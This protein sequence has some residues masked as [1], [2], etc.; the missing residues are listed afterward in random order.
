MADSKPVGRIVLVFAALLVV[1]G[2]LMKP[3]F[4]RDVAQLLRVGDVAYS[5]QLIQSYG[6]YAKL[7]VFAIIVLI[8]ILAVLPNIFVLAAAGALFGIVEGTLVAWAAETVGV[9]VSFLLMR[10][11]FRR[12]AEK[13][14][15]RRGAHHRL[16]ELS[17]SNGFRIILLARSTPYVPSGLIT[18]LAALSRVRFRDH[19]LAT[20]IGKLPSAWVEVTVGHDLFSYRAHLIRLVM[21]IVASGLVYFLVLRGRRRPMEKD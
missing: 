18:A 8:N 5:I 11:L 4:F 2:Y 16:K 20:A 14:I 19:F 13:F 6:Q 12:P 9:S 7:A 15:E 1:S 17:G 10:Y 21:L 3:E